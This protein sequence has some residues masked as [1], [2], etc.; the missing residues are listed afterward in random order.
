VSELNLISNIFE[1]KELV[2]SFFI[3]K[4]LLLLFL[5]RRYYLRNKYYKE[6]IEREK[7]YRH[8][9]DNSITATLISGNNG[10]IRMSNLHFEKL[11]GFHTDE[12]KGK[13]LIEVVNIIN[14]TEKFTEQ[15]SGILH[16]LNATSWPISVVKCKTDKEI[17][18]YTHI[19]DKEDEKYTIMS[20]IRSGGD[21]KPS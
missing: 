9:F 20:F 8:L 16:E 6:I 18:C 7:T 3:F 17:Y 21:N 5:G 12:L 10:I 1:H 2:A 11:T 19:H 15:N 14:G 4:F 13:K